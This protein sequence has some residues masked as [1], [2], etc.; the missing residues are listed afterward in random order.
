MFGAVVKQVWLYPL[1]KLDS[2]AAQMVREI[3]TSL[4]KQT[5]Q[6]LEIFHIMQMRSNDHIKTKVYDYFPGYQYQLSQFREMISE[7]IVDFMKQIAAILPQIRGGGLEEEKLAELLRSVHQSPFNEGSLSKWLDAKETEIKVLSQYIDIIMDKAPGITF[8]FAPGDLDSIV[9]DLNHNHVVSFEFKVATKSDSFLE[10]MFAFLRTQNV[11]SDF[12]AAFPKQWFK[13]K[14]LMSDVRLKAEQFT[15]FAQANKDDEDVKFVVTD[16]SEDDGIQDDKGA[17]VLH[18]EFGS[19]EEF[20]P[21]DQ[22]SKPTAA[23]VTHKSVQLEWKQPQYG[24]QSIKSYTVLY[25]YTDDPGDWKTQKTKQAETAITINQLVPQGE[26]VFKVRAEC[27]FGSSEESKVCL[28][29]TSPSPRD[30]TRS[31]MPSSA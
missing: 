14:A 30:R 4:V 9:N 16:S 5:Q 2:K 17:L 29:Y 15:S 28:L 31:R 23:H 10:S 22:P 3:S 13:N 19:P 8:A 7:F 25:R 20:E 1:N 27:N 11:S 18:Y 6:F 26:Y 12:S 21:P 24:V